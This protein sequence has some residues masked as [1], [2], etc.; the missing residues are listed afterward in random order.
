MINSNFLKDVDIA[1]SSRPKFISS[2]Y[3]YDEK[4]SK[5]FQ[6]IM[7]MDEY[8]LT[9]AEF[10]IFN[11]QGDAIAEEI[12]SDDIEFDLV[13]LGAGDGLKSKLLIRHLLNSNRKFN[14]RPIDISSSAIE[15]LSAELKTEFPEL[16]VK[17]EVGEYFEA[18]KSMSS[19]NENRP[20]LVLFLGS[21]LGNFRKENAIAF[22]KQMKQSMRQGDKILIGIDLQKD[23]H[24]IRMAYDDPH[25][26]T[27]RFNLNL[28][29][30]INREMNANF[31]LEQFGHYQSYD[32]QT[33]EVRS[34]IFS[35]EDQ[36]IHVG[37]LQKE[38]HFHKWEMM[39][40]EISRKYSLLELDELAS[41]C[42]F[43]LVS[44]FIDSNGYF[45]DTLWEIK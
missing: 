35:K 15:G 19:E 29:N 14:Y 5:I 45:S 4:G 6:E 31:N 9:K 23:P 43:D 37:A 25:G 33:G 22:L 8:Y 40:T 16:A 41:I 7:A 20:K 1:L 34:Y 30:R 13:E 44:R 32:P 24:L 10:E 36:T 18:L 17:A 3:F 39:H 2:K 12:Y 11:L 28:L 38:Y 21:N 42:E 27:K 26:I